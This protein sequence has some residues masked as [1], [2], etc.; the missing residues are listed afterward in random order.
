MTDDNETTPSVGDFILLAQRA[1]AQARTNLEMARALSE[2]GESYLAKAKAAER[3]GSSAIGGF[4]VLDETRRSG[5][6]KTAPLTQV[7]LGFAAVY[8]RAP[9]KKRDHVGS[10]CAQR[11][12]SRSRCT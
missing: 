11:H 12:R 4:A 5:R 1:F 8:S 3:Q 2:M 7:P 9:A 6:Y 10:R